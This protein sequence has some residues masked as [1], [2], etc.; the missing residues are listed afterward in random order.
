MKNLKK[1]SRKDQQQIN[2]GGITLC[3]TDS[4]C[5]YGSCCNGVCMEHACL[6]P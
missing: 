1:L 3:K 5:V 6:E 4:Q 2:G